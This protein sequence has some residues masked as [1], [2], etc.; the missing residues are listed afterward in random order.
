MGVERNK[1]SL[2][3]AVQNSIKDSFR[4]NTFCHKTFIHI[5][6]VIGRSPSQIKRN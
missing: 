5:L 3:Q 1:C 4:F 6:K 2:F